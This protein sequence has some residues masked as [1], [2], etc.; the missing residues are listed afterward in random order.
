MNK[1]SVREKELLMF[2]GIFLAVGI[3]FAYGIN[4][5]RPLANKITQQLEK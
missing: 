5:E 3:L 2:L 1:L 4:S